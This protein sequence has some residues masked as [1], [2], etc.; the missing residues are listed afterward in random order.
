MGSCCCCCKEKEPQPSP[1]ITFH[2]NMKCCASGDMLDG[3]ESNTELKKYNTV[4]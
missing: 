1:T 2:V 4:L 3:E